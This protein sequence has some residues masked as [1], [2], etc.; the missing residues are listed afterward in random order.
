[1]GDVLHLLYESAR[2]NIELKDADSVAFRLLAAELLAYEELFQAPTPSSAPPPVQVTLVGWWPKSDSGGS[3]WPV[4]LKVHSPL[5]RAIASGEPPVRSRVGLVS[6][7]YGKAIQWSGQGPIPRGVRELLA[8]AREQAASYGAP[9]RVHH[10]PERQQ[11]YAWLLAEGVTLI[12]AEDLR[13]TRAL[14]E[15][16]LPSTR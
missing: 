8:R 2:L 10:V 5:A 13:R 4:F 14:L 15:G 3:S 1:M 6:I 7:D 9:I 16:S 11:V 12:G